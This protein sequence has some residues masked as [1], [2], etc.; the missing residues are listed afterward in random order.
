MSD[1]WLWS[2]E[3]S[4]LAVAVEPL[5][6]AGNE[7]LVLVLEDDQR[8]ALSAEASRDL[9][10]ALADWLTVEAPIASD[11][12]YFQ[13]YYRHEYADAEGLIV[14]CPDL[15]EAD[16]DPDEHVFTWDEP[17]GEGVRRRVRWIGQCVAKLDAGRAGDEPLPDGAT[18]WVSIYRMPEDLRVWRGPWNEL[19]ETP[20]RELYE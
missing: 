13:V 6:E 8:V 2:D 3:E 1:N 7:G 18:P 15:G 17:D 5:G 12:D 14:P 10:A 20:D 4:G 16:G 19:D 9:A 11:S